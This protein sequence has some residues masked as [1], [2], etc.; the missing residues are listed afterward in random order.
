M[1][2]LFVLGSGS[3]GNAFAVETPEGVLM[4]EAGF[5]LRTLER[6][7]EASGLDLGRVTGIFLTH[8]HGDH[9]AGAIAL[10]ERT[11]APILCSRGT[12]RS[13]AAPP[14]I[15][16][17]PILP[18][19][20]LVF[21]T[22][23]VHSTLTSHDAEEPLA[24]A[25]ELSSGLRFAFAT[26]IGRATAGI[27]Y[28]LRESHAVVL[29]SNYDDLMLRTGRYPPSVQARIAGAGG[30]ISN[31]G[32]AELLSQVVHAGTEVVVLSH[33][34]QQCNTAERARETVEPV[35]RA[36]GFGGAL[37]VAAQD[38]PLPPISVAVRRPDQ[39]ELGLRWDAASPAQSSSA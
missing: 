6:R 13:L 38:A 19:R 7:A 10:A 29:E 25:M 1:T 30:H 17:V 16:H 35:L 22:I 9:A 36:R 39:G 3:R 20:P 37:H 2:R 31:R 14:E 4:V 5:G 33:L 21:G 32:A 26:D 23:T 34:S 24:L 11:G 18:A 15:E 8:E 12:W 27:R 28:L